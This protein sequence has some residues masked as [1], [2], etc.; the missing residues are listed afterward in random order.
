[1]V[2]QQD[3]ATNVDISYKMSRDSSSMNAVTILTLIFLPGTF[4]SVS[5]RRNHSHKILKRRKWPTGA[6]RKLQL[7]TCLDCVLKCRIPSRQFRRSTNH[8]VLRALPY[9]WHR[10]DCRVFLRVV[11]SETARTVA[12]ISFLTGRQGT[13]ESKTERFWE[14][15]LM[16]F[17]FERGTV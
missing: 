12:E 2:T 10:S 5:C 1:M 3:S 9:H 15:G 16:C 6:W 4:I 8:A 17:F 7:L 11:L 14:H 13:L